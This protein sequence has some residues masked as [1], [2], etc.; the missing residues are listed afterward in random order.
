MDTTDRPVED[1]LRRRAAAFDAV[2][3]ADGKNLSSYVPVN[4]DLFPEAYR[5][6]S[7]RN[8]HAFPRGLARVRQLYEHAFRWAGVNVA[9]FHGMVMESSRINNVI[10]VVAQLARM[11]AVSDERDMPFD[12]VLAHAMFVHRNAFVLSPF[13]AAF[14]TATF[15]DADGP[16]GRLREGRAL[17]V[18]TSDGQ[19]IFDDEILNQLDRGRQL[20]DAHATRVPLHV[21]GSAAQGAT[22]QGED[23]RAQEYGPRS[24]A[25]IRYVD[26]FAMVIQFAAYRDLPNYRLLA[27]RFAATKHADERKGEVAPRSVFALRPLP[28]QSVGSYTHDDYLN[29]SDMACALL[30]LYYDVARRA[31]QWAGSVEDG[32]GNHLFHV[33]LDVTNPFNA[34]AL[35]E[36]DHQA[37][38]PEAERAMGIVP[39]VAELAA[40][41]AGM[42]T[43]ER[44]RFP[45]AWEGHGKRKQ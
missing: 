25:Y 8:G 35:D 39:D 43:G 6:W 15:M 12:F 31:W 19:I 38:A 1:I 37:T 10:H 17:N 34:G 29:A 18:Q 32:Q 24:L 14:D 7:E 26:P 40:E 21:T 45:P 13:G 30:V 2:V 9:S 20:R 22:G 23:P 28:Q 5:W 3:Q 36:L 33:I 41:F 4:R 27:R 11:F 44:P 42:Q 16:L